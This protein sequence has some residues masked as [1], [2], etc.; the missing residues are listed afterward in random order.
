MSTLT[1]LRTRLALSILPKEAWRPLDPQIQPKE[2]HAFNMG[3]SGTSI[4]AGY[5]DE[6]YLKDIRG[7][8]WAERV[9]MIRRS[10]SNASM[11]LR[12]LKLPIKSANWYASI[13][14]GIDEDD[15][16]VMAMAEMQKT[17]ISKAFFEDMRTSFT[18]LLGEILTMYDNG[19]SLFESTFK[20]KFDDKELGT[21]NTIK[22][23]SFRSQ[24]TIE[25]W[26]LRQDGS[27]ES[28][29]QI[30]YGD[31]GV[32]VDIPGE[33][34]VHFAQEMEGDNYEGISILRPMYGNWK[35]KNA[36][37]KWIA[38]GNEKSAIPTP[39]LQ[40]PSNKQGVTGELESAETMIKNYSSGSQNYIMF[41]EGYIL[42]QFRL[43]FDPEKMLKCVSYEDQAMV[44]SILASFLLLGQNGGGSLALGKDLSDFFGQT[45]KSTT[46]YISEVLQKNIVKTLIKMK[47]GD[48]P[49]YVSVKCED[50]TDNVDQ[51]F[52]TT[53][54]LFVESGAITPDSP[55][56]RFIREKFQLPE[57]DPTTAKKKQ[58]QLPAPTPDPEDDIKEKAKFSEMGKSSTPELIRQTSLDLKEIFESQISALGMDYVQSIMKGFSS[59]TETGKAKVPNLTDLPNYKFY[60]DIVSY[61]NMQSALS[62]TAKLQNEGVKLSESA[63]KFSMVSHRARVLKMN[64]LLVRIINLSASYSTS[65]DY[66]KTKSELYKLRREFSSMFYGYKQDIPQWKSSKLRNEIESKTATLIDTQMGDL[67]KK[68]D[69]QY[70]SSLRSTDSARQLEYDMLE[71]KDTLAGGSAIA[72]GADI[73]ASQTVNETRLQISLDDP[74]VESYTFIAIDDSKTSDIC[75]ELNGR[76][77][78]PND[79]Q[80]DRYSPPL[81]YN[82]RSYL[83]INMKGS[84]ENPEISQ[85]PFAPTESALKSISLSHQKSCC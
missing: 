53:L 66:M 57:A 58:E 30:A 50:L 54:K 85:G 9:D 43:D 81:H 37:L 13:N 74:S 63:F 16:E 28:V 31:L 79:P 83:Q 72:S 51:V 59:S 6:E 8:D 45:F 12:A 39:T 48:V 33:Y 17:L 78:S 47:W 1:N 10:D 60:K 41:P 65:A 15:A 46:D 73:I 35:R 34:L 25:R 22:S 42:D 82:C 2:T 11:C 32:C 76:T 56:E 55:L 84:K 49:C 75:L 40:I 21:Y 24:K 14:E 4:Y 68:I 70:Q 7:K 20:V 44:N 19:Y 61:I 26:N 36:Y 5:F 29:T 23:I 80:L 62:A 38:G 52:A 67:K 69:L 77:F 27:L 71:A 18:Q 64:E 3:S